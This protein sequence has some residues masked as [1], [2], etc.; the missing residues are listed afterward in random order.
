[1]KS[2]RMKFSSTMNA[3]KP[4]SRF[5]CGHSAAG[6]NIATARSTRPQKMPCTRFANGPAALVTMMSREG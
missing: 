5:V 1:M 3:R 6:L 4:T 2:A